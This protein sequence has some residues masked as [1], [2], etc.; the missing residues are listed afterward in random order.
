MAFDLLEFGGQELRTA[1][2]IERFGHLR[3][4]ALAV[5]TLVE[6]R[7][8]YRYADCKF[9]QPVYKGRRPDMMPADAALSQVTR[10]QDRSAVLDDDEAA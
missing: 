3:K 6:V 4:V 9:E 1:A 10:I 2:F 8:L 5:G 7:C